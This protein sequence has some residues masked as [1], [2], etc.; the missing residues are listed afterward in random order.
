MI[1]LKDFFP[2]GA[3]ASSGP[4]HPRYRRITLTLRHTTLGRTSGRVISPMQ[5]PLPH[6]TQHS[7]ETGIYSRSRIRTR[8]PSK[9]AAARLRIRPRGHREFSGRYRALT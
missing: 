2:R 4:G 7:Q 9:R 8:N 5:R 1:Q 3:T 6:K